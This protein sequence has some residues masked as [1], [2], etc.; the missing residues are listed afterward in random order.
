M[1]LTGAFTLAG[2]QL[3]CGFACGEMRRVE[4]GRGNLDACLTFPLNHNQDH[5]T[6]T[7]KHTRCSYSGATRCHFLKHQP[8]SGRV[9]N[10]KAQSV[11]QILLTFYTRGMVIQPFLTN[12]LAGWMLLC[13]CCFKLKCHFNAWP[14]FSII[15]SLHYGCNKATT[16]LNYSTAL[17]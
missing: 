11:F 6:I 9:T 1:R 15:S 14:T 2:A 3:Q 12:R 16:K 5:V 10:T 7:H 8:V 13:C 17:P 4:A